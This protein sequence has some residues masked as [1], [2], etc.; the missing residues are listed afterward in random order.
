MPYLVI[1]TTF[2]AV[3]LVCIL[4]LLWF[5]ASVLA[6][7]AERRQAIHDA[8]QAKRVRLAG[9]SRDR[10]IDQRFAEACR[11]FDRSPAGRRLR[12]LGQGAV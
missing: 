8:R 9:Y 5:N 10:E 6:P 3:P 1:P 12:R 4:A 2:G 11:A 7:R